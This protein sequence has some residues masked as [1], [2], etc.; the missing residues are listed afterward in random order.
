MI[1]I[2]LDVPALQEGTPERNIQCISIQC[3]SADSLDNTLSHF[4]G[5]PALLLHGRVSEVSEAS[6]GTYSEYETE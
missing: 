1:D 4:R 3:I 6:E 5:S 2:A